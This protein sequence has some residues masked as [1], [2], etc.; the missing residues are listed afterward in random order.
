MENLIV[1][2][3]VQRQIDGN[4]YVEWRPMNEEIQ[5]IA[6]HGKVFNSKDL[7]LEYEAY[8]HLEL[9]NC[10]NGY[11]GQDFYQVNA[12]SVE[13]SLYIKRKE[14]GIQAVNAL[15]AEL[16]NRSL[17]LGIPDSVNRHIENRLVSVKQNVVDGWWKSALDEI[18]F[19][20]PD[21]YLTQDLIDRVRNTISKYIDEN[22]SIVFV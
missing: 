5:E 9:V 13:H 20:Q 3:K 6:V 2:R 15:M 22:Y 11:F 7:I 18:I 4:F 21:E 17:A 8:A 12:N 1:I 14:D 10:I 16:R 19:I